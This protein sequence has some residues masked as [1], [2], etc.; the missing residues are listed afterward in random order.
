M[1]LLKRFCDICDYQF[2]HFRSGKGKFHR[3]GQWTLRPGLS[4]EHLKHQI[5]AWQWAL[6]PGLSLEH[7]KHQISACMFTSGHGAVSVASRPQPGAPE[8]PDLCMAVSVSSRPQPGAPEAP[9]TACMFTSGHGAVSVASRP[10]PGAPKA[11]DLCMYVRHWQWPRNFPFIAFTSLR[12]TFMGILTRLSTGSDSHMDYI[13]RRNEG[14]LTKTDDERDG[15]NC[16]RAYGI[17]GWGTDIARKRRG[18]RRSE[19]IKCV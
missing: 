1:S 16:G 3:T 6:R 18:I 10:Q 4:L 5:S 14:T 9:I 15:S 13:H 8:A 17:C 7:L 2:Q 19:R 11:P 12:A